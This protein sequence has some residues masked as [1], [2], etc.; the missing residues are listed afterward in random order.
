[1]F[2][3]CR[4][5]LASWEGDY[6]AIKFTTRNNAYSPQV[7]ANIFEK[8]AEILNELSHSNIIQI[9][10]AIRQGHYLKDGRDEIRAALVF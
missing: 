7:L 10:E 5:K 8:E 1:M 6:Y 9:V 3:L 4:V 2:F